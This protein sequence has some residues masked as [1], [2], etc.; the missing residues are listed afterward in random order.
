MQ[1]ITII[2]T[3]KYLENFR[4]Y[5]IIVNN[6]INFLSYSSYYEQI[7]SKKIKELNF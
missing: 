7:S 1:Y 2:I 6:I 3:T 5:N 4:N